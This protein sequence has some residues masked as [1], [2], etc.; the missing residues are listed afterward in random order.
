[1]APVG[2]VSMGAQGAER[3]VQHV[4]AGLLSR[5]STD[6]VNG[7]QLFASNQQT[8][9]NCN[10]IVSLDSRMTGAETGFGNLDTRVTGTEG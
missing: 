3:S 5:G 4:A 2:V 7:S 10:D 6:A 8:T 1:A 9:L